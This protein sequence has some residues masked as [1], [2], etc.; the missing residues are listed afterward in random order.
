MTSGSRATSRNLADSMPVASDDFVEVSSH[1]STRAHST[2]KQRFADFETELAKDEAILDDLANSKDDEQ[3]Q[4]SRHQSTVSFS[5]TTTTAATTTTTTTAA[6]ATTAGSGTDATA[7]AQGQG[8]DSRNA[9]SE[10]LSEA[11]S[12]HSSRGSPD[13]HD[14]SRAAAH[15]HEQREDH[16][17]AHHRNRHI[18]TATRFA[19]EGEP[20]AVDCV[21]CL[22]QGKYFIRAMELKGDPSLQGQ[23]SDRA[24]CTKF[25]TSVQMT[26]AVGDGKVQYS[27]KDAAALCGGAQAGDGTD[28]TTTTGDAHPTPPKVTW[29]QQG[30]EACAAVGGAVEY[31]DFPNPEG[32]GP[33]SARKGVLTFGPNDPIWDAPR[34]PFPPDR[35][36]D[37][38]PLPSDVLGTSSGGQGQTLDG[39]PIKRSMTP[40]E[41]QTLQRL[42]GLIRHFEANH[43]DARRAV[44]V[45]PPDLPPCFFSILYKAIYEMPEAQRPHPHVIDMLRALYNCLQRIICQRYL[46]PKL[47]SQSPHGKKC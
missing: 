28:G 14:S 35:V 7:G 32:P 5:A 41:Q 30:V 34:P 44:K 4:R 1:S 17:T 45:D 23:A 19:S 24:R 33:R 27:E 37:F 39:S 31:V 2:E 43:E 21:K 40:V 6:T 3:G 46:P 25:P 10:Q 38:C 11:R 13:I 22:Q 42:T 16:S 15:D 18:H 20:S 26:A 36:G 29:S 12:S 47:K 9:M 8:A